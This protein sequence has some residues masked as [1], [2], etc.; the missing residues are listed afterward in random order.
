MAIPKKGTRTITVEKD[1]YRW[2]IRRKATYGQSD[3]GIG[4]I[5]V[6]IEHAENPGTTL[7]IYTDRE[8]PKD[9]NTKNVIPVT[10]SDISNW[11]KQALELDWEP[12]KKG[13]QL[14]FSIKEG[15]MKK[16]N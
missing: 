8:H 1:I 15:K 14:S 10:P 6:A 7:F 9:W 5:H 12:E 4:R 2:L 13:P 3:Y 11:I 16:S